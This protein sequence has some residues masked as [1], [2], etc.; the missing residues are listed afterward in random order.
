MNK[1]GR[2]NKKTSMKT[3]PTIE[4]G[5]FLVIKERDYWQERRLLKNGKQH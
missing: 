2:H 5:L 3:K 4:N 1:K